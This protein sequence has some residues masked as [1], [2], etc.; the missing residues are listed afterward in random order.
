MLGAPG[1]YL[2]PEVPRRRLDAEPMD[3]VGFVGVAPR[4]PAWEPVD[5]PTLGT[6]AAARARSVPV[7]VDSW[8]DYRELFGGFEGPGLL[9]HAVAAFFAQG[10]R[11]AVV[12]CGS[13]APP[14]RGARP[15][16]SRPAAPATRSAS[17]VPPL[18]ARS[19]GSWGNRL[20]ATLAFTTRGARRR[21]RPDAALV[22]EP[23]SGLPVGALV[24]LRTPDLPDALA[25]VAR[26]TRVGRADA[27]GADLVAE[28]DRRV[29]HAAAASV[30]ELVEAELDGRRPPTRERPRRERFTGLG[31]ARPS[32]AI[33]PTCSGAG[34]GCLLPSSCRSALPTTPAST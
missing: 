7:T 25:A 3:V 18:R 2:A 29:D 10:G 24:R 6:G 11:R 33:S 16:P 15:E 14:T 20:M 12:G 19:E 23:G 31:R 17:G 4:G 5:D 30:T 9:P 26:L 27:A 8:D 32:A 28:L 34:R 21:E 22:L 13:S 1:V